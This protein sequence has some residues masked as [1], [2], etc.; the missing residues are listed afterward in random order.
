M[1]AY[2]LSFVYTVPGIAFGIIQ[3]LKFVKAYISTTV[4][5]FAIPST[6]MLDYFFLQKVPNSF[7]LAGVVLIMFGIVFVSAQTWRKERQKERRVE[8]LQTLQFDPDE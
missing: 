3:A 2:M 5:M 7:H 6:L 4:R 1:I 8:F